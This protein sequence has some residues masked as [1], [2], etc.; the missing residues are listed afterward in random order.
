M[1]RHADDFKYI[2]YTRKKS[3]SIFPSPAGMSLTE[4]SPGVNNLYMTSLFPPRESL[5][6]EIPA[7]DGNI[8]K[9]FYGVYTSPCEEFYMS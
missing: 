7:D 3:F 9:F 8:E 5:V 1:Q 4:L 2:Q 6:S